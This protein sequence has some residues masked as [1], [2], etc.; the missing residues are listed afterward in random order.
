MIGGYKASSSGLYGALT[1]HHAKLD[2]SLRHVMATLRLEGPAAAKM[3]FDPF[4]RELDAQLE[5]EETWLLPPYERSKP[6]AAE[7]VLF[8]HV[9]VRAAATLAA[10]QLDALSAEERPL[11]DLYDVLALHCRCEESDLYQWS[12][13]AIGEEDSRAVLQKIEAGE[14]QEPHG[15]SR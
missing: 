12:E 5:A 10:A 3:A 9:K 4:Q 15:W 1:F 13:T 11:Q 2:A 7:A 6:K 8:Q 14:L